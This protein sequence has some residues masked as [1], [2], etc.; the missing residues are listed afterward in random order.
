MASKSLRALRYAW[1]EACNTMWIEIA[2]IRHLE[3]TLRAEFPSIASNAQL[4]SI[5]FTGEAEG[6]VLRTKHQ[7]LA[8][9]DEFVD[10]SVTIRVV[11]LSSAFEAFFESFL[12]S[13]LRARTRYYVAGTR[14]RAGDKVFG[15]VIRQRGLVQRILKFSE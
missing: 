15:E 2:A 8:G 9:I 6:R 5:I 10:Y 14:T 7:L 1:F 12:D 4:S 11:L 3:T 13:F